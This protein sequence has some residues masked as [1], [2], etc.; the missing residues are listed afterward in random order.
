MGGARSLDSMEEGVS[1]RCLFGG[2]LLVG[3]E[4]GIIG[5]GSTPETTWGFGVFRIC[6]GHLRSVCRW[7]LVRIVVVS[8]VT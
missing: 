5:Q 2:L 8:E 1:G 3:S 4:A 6:P 7:I